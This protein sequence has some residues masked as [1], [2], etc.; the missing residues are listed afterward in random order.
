MPVFFAKK[1]DKRVAKPKE[2]KYNIHMNIC[3]YVHIK[4]CGDF[5]GR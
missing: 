5:N 1:N 3:S 2:I 4:D